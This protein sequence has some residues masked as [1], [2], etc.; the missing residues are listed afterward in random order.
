MKKSESMQIA[1][2]KLHIFG[3]L[4]LFIIVLKYPLATHEAQKSVIHQRE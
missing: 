1:N 4:I 2:K 3:F